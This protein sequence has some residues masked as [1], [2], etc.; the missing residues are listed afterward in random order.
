[1]TMQRANGTAVA[2]AP[3]GD[4]FDFDVS[5]VTQTREVRAQNVQRGALAGTVAK[6][7]ANRMGLPENVPWTLREDS[8][9]AFLDDNR[10]IGEQLSPESKTTL[11]PKTHLG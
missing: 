5:D 11:T 7:L 3:F 2:D 4:V 6:A 1:M 10:P 9:S 8:T